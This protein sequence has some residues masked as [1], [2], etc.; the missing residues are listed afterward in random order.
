M[1]YIT[2]YTSLN[3]PFNNNHHHIHP[4]NHIFNPYILSTRWLRTQTCEFSGQ[5]AYELLGV[6]ETSCI[7]EIKAAFIKLAKQTHP[8][9][10]VSSASSEHFVQILAAYEILSD[11]EKRVNYDRYLLSQRMFV[12][13]H[14]KQHYMMYHYELDRAPKHMEVVEWLEWY[15]QAIKDIL[16][17]ERVGTGSGYFDVLHMDFYS[18]IHAAYYGPDIEASDLL[19]ECFEAEERSDYGTP[20]VLHLVSGREL[21]GMICVSNK[22]PELAHGFRAKKL[23][24]S[25]DPF[26]SVT[27]FNTEM[28]P[29]DPIAVISES[30]ASNFSELSEAYKDLELHIMGKRVAVATRNPPKNSCGIQDDDDLEDHIHVYLTSKQGTVYSPCQEAPTDAYSSFPDETR[31]YLGSITGLGTSADE[32][33]CSFFSSTGIKTH[34]IMKHRTFL[35]KHLHWYHVGD[36]VSICECRCSRARLPPSKYW[37]FEPR[38]GMHDVGGWYVETFGKDKKG[39]TVKAQRFWDG[40][41]KYEENDKRVHPAIYLLSLAYRTLDLEDSRR[42]KQNIK[43]ILGAKMFRI[44]GW[45]KKL[46]Q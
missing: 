10:N 29:L 24:T 25:F 40:L 46:V 21:F 44:L 34:V 26:C 13:R 32:G 30:R 43:D 11:S 19:P 28:D 9:L 14:A 37:L 2:Q 7:A 16:A 15:R 35:V 42:K 17:E 1:R 4:I 23:S 41:H 12:Q 22:T 5:N 3:A 6:S 36:E 45:C 8:D 18:A 31:F 33:S 20:E 39:R 38:C 27:N